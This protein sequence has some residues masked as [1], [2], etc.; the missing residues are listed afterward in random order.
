MLSPCSI[1]GSNEHYTKL[2]YCRHQ[3]TQSEKAG[4]LHWNLTEDQIFSFY[5]SIYIHFP[6]SYRSYLWQS[7]S[8]HVLSVY[9]GNWNTSKV[10]QRVKPNPFGQWLQDGVHHNNF[11]IIP[12]QTPGTAPIFMVTD[13]YS[14]RNGGKTPC[15]CNYC[16]EEDRARIVWWVSTAK[17]CSQMFYVASK[18][19][20]HN[21]HDQCDTMVCWRQF[22]IHAI[23]YISVADLFMLTILAYHCSAF[24]TLCIHHWGKSTKGHT[25]SPPTLCI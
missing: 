7:F 3:E 9:H 12:C 14:W 5:R 15:W 2:D 19:L 1:D 13:Y 17:K 21:L 4:T 18:A 11:I 23:P 22:A 8:V 25:S 16:R 24:V 20:V 6:G 10:I